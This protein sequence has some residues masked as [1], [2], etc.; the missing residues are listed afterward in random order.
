ME[1]TKR[2]E[3]GIANFS[4]VQNF[5]CVEDYLLHLRQEYNIV[6]DPEVIQM[7]KAIN[8]RSTYKMEYRV[9]CMD[10][11]LFEKR[12]FLISSKKKAKEC[13]LKTPN[14]VI[15][16]LLYD[17]FLQDETLCRD[18]KYFI[19][20]HNE[21]E[22]NL[23]DEFSFLAI[24]NEGRIPRLVRYIDEP[25]PGVGFISEADSIVFMK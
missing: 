15:A 2:T 13:G 24:E 12:T 14:P 4:I 16:C 6:P 17:L 20:L 11:G 19:I 10:G 1:I 7:L 23:C 22:A 21:I 5:L 9:A 3:N 18:K 25:L 8:F